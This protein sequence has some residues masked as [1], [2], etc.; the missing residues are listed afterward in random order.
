MYDIIV[1][2]AGHAGV[3]A[4]LASARMGLNTLLITGNLDTISQMSCNPAIGGLAKGHLVREID[5]LGGEMG[6]SID[7]TGIHFKM[8]NRSKGPAVWAPRA[9]ADKKAYQFLMKEVIEKTKNLFSIQDVVKSIIVENGCVKGVVTEREMTHESKAVIICSGTFLK[10]LIHIGAQQ[11]HA[12]RLADFS[13]EYLSESLRDHGLEV[14]RLKTGTPQ[15]IN[16]NSIDFTKCEIQYPDEKPEPFSFSNESVSFIPAGKVPCWVTYTTLKTHEIIRNNLKYS[17]LY[18]GAIKGIGP[19]YC[20]SIED[21]VV[22]F[23]EKDRHQLFLE[24]EGLHTDEYYINGFSTSLPEFIQ[25]EMLHS[26]P[27][28]ETAH[29]MR[30]AYAVEYDF[31][32][33]TQLRSTL[34][35]KKIEGLY[36]AGQI[37][38]TSGYEEAA[39][40]GLIA[41]IN[42]ALKIKGRDPLILSRSDAYI[43]VLIDDLVTKGTEEPYRMFTSRAEHRLVL[44]QDNADERLCLKGYDIGLVSEDIF[45]RTKEKYDAIGKKIGEIKQTVIT[46]TEEMKSLIVENPDMLFGV[47]GKTS[48]EKLVKRPEVSLLK[49]IAAAGLDIDE[50]IAAIAEME[51]KYEGY[52]RKEEERISRLSHLDSMK[53]PDGFDYTNI[54]GIRKE[55]RDK[56]NRIKPETIGQARRI[57]GVDPTDISILVVYI[58]NLSRRGGVPRGTNN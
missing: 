6:K 33:P 10:G 19:R 55:G 7:A 15:R 14:K 34:E 58:E 52:I 56:L 48:L 39:A 25:L 45:E 50:K 32:P 8:L 54:N 4:A 47:R 43:G 2:G 51:I 44:R 21:K 30:P 31:V 35:T 46:V 1:I 13:S 27:G 37:N 57:S 28:L 49:V 18:G 9:Q 29:V 42:A 22:R 38:G 11:Q 17:P 36:H 40:Q 26:L 12:G 41:G 53:I 3:E 23:A 24:P 20:P 16:G 5:A